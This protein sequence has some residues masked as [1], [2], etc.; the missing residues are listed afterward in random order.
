M[1]GIVMSEKR[2]EPDCND[3]CHNNQYDYSI[4][5]SRYEANTERNEIIEW[6]K[7]KDNAQYDNLERIAEELNFKQMQLE[8]C[9][10]GYEK[11]YEENEQL[12]S[13]YDT[14]QIQDD[15]RKQYQKE[16]M[17]ENEELKEENKKLKLKIN[18][19]HEGNKTLHKTLQKYW[20][21][22]YNE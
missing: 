21:D 9:R 1:E 12:R 7:Y 13:D 8:E 15:A 10:K 16:L 3:D 19:Y 5:N 20:E 17:K 18:T 14:L 4:L 22:R 2:F 11:L 6:N